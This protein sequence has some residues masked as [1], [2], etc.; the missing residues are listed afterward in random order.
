LDAKKRKV[1][2]HDY[3]V[4]RNNEEACDFDEALVY[5]AEISRPLSISRDMGPNVS[6]SLGE[7]L[8]VPTWDEHSVPATRLVDWPWCAVQTSIGAGIFGLMQGDVVVSNRLF[9]SIMKNVT[10]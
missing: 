3:I 5:L 2:K 7:S 4:L 1:R 8:S 9:T 6:R 10:T